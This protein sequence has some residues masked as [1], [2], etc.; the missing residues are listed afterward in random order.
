MRDFSKSGSHYF[1]FSLFQL[2]GIKTVIVL[3]NT[4]WPSGYPPSRFV[5]RLIGRLDSLFF[6][7]LPIATIGVSPECIRQVAQLTN[8]RHT[9]LF[10]IR[11]QFHRGYFRAI[12]PPP[13][14]DQRPFKIVYV[15]RITRNKG[16]Y[17]ILEIAKRIEAQAP[18][19]TQWE[20]CGSG[21]DL[22]AI[23]RLHGEIDLKETVVIRGWMSPMN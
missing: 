12:P 16:V 3:H 17:D 13:P 7:W 9:P 6:R 1:I 10:Q 15:G 2:V 19:R 21:P 20:I 4:V 14:H 18:R 22:E 5:P 23:R 11:A 8:G